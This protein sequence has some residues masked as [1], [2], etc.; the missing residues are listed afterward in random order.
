[1]DNLAEVILFSAWLQAMVLL[2]INAGNQFWY[3]AGFWTF[4]TGLGAWALL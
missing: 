4:V 2:A 3:V 1:M